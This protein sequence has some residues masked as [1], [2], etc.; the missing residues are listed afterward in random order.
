MSRSTTSLSLSSKSNLFQY[1]SAKKNYLKK[2]KKKNKKNKKIKK[3]KKKKKKQ[4]L[5]N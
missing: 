4:K 1:I 2:K 5:S 3:K